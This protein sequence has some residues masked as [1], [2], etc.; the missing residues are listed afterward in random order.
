M[1]DEQPAKVAER[2]RQE[3]IDRA[4]AKLCERCAAGMP[5]NREWSHFDNCAANPIRELVGELNYEG[6]HCD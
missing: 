5:Y 1:S 2:A 3:V 6:K 4:I